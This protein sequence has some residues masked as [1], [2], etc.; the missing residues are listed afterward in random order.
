MSD[1]AYKI[2]PEVSMTVAWSE[3]GLVDNTPLSGTTGLVVFYEVLQQLQDSKVRLTLTS[4][5]ISWIYFYTACHNGILYNFSHN[6][7]N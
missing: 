5:R 1:H 6:L 3:S 4:Q 7:T 2:P